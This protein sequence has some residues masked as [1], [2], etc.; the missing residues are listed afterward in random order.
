MTQYFKDTIKH[1]FITATQQQN[2]HYNNIC[3][4]ISIQRFLLNLTKQMYKK[5]QKKYMKFWTCFYLSL[6]QQHLQ[7]AED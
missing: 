6:K 3:D 7:L 4:K 2:E 1:I 5:K